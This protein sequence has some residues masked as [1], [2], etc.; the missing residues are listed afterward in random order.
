[1]KMNGNRLESGWQRWLESNNR[2]WG[3]LGTLYQIGRR[4][5]IRY[6]THRVSDHVPVVL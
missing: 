4:V 6:E 2:G 3:G 1:M 5:H